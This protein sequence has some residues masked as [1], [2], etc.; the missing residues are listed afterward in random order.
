LDI[1]EEQIIALAVFR[2]L[3]A[4]DLV[5]V[6]KLSHSSYFFKRLYFQSHFYLVLAQPAIIVVIN[7][8]NGFDNQKQPFEVDTLNRNRVD[9]FF[10]IL[11]LLYDA[12][13]RFTIIQR[14]I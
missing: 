10:A 5:M 3:S 14:A 2:R 1:G 4:Y 8:P 11:L 7:V 6:L 12:D 9:P 13:T